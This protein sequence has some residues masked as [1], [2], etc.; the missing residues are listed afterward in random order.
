MLLVWPFAEHAID[1]GFSMSTDEEV[2]TSRLHHAN[3][4]WSNSAIYGHMTLGGLLTVLVLLQLIGPLRQRFP[5][6]HRNLGYALAGLAV[7]TGIGGLL[8][9]F[10]QGTIGG[11]VMDIGFGLYGCLIIGTAIQTV[12][13]ARQRDPRHREWALRLFILALGSWLYRV[14]YGLWYL[15]TDGMYSNPDFTGGF[16]LVQTFAFYLPYLLILEFWMRSRMGY[17]AFS[18]PSR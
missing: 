4:W 11:R 5:A 15:L 12:R 16:D 9:I 10:W 18:F 13:F 6:V 17:K 2:L 14:H 7:L 1:R 3:E 8:Y